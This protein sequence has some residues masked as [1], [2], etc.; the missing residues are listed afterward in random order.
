M[1]YE[2]GI[3]ANCGVDKGLHHFETM[4]CPKN[5]K[6]EIRFDKLSGKFLPQRW[7]NTVFED[8]GIK[9]VKD[10]SFD[11]LRSLKI[12]TSLCKIKY[13]NLDKEVYEEILKSE[14]LIDR[15]TK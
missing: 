5:G 11:L 2:T 10:A 9:K 7:E 8:S 3:C 12:M 4:Q 15:L 14:E 1:I 6:E 13:G